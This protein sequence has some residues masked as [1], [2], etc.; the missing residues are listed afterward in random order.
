[1]ENTENTKTGQNQEPAGKPAGGGN[2]H[3]LF[4]GVI[5]AALALGLIIP[6]LVS[7]PES[8]IEK[9]LM[10]GMLPFLVLILWKQNK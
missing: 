2:L 8:R 5:A 9:F 7:F 4:I 6:G 10:A 3:V 1:M